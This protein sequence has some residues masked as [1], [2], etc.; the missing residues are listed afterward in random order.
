MLRQE[1]YVGK[2]FATQKKIFALETKHDIYSNSDSSLS[3]EF[4]FIVRMTRTM[5][6]FY[7]RWGE[8]KDFIVTMT[9]MT[10]NSGYKA[11]VDKFMTIS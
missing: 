7:V 3:R 2:V 5:R 1:A 4:Q 11:R 9:V 8:L 10:E 6:Q